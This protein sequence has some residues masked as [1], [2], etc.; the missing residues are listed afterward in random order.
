MLNP[1]VTHPCGLSVGDRSPGGGRVRQAAP[2][3]A[4]A[5][6]AAGRRRRGAGDGRHRV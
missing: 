4:G 5:A 6:A 1:H 3:A 2:L